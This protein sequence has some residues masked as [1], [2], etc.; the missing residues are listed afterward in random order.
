M[1][2]ITFAIPAQIGGGDRV[3][4]PL[5]AFGDKN[6]TLL[7]WKIAQLLN[8]T[9]GKNIL[10]SSYSDKVVAEAKSLGVV[11]EKRNRSYDEEKKYSH[12]EVVLEILQSVN[13][14]FVAWISPV[15]PFYDELNIQS[16]LEIFEKN[17][18]TNFCD[19]LI[20]VKKIN[21]YILDAELKPV[22]FELNGYIKTRKDTQPYYAY[23][24]AFAVAATRAAKKNGYYCGFKPIT[25]TLEGIEAI[26]INSDIE[27]ENAQK[28]VTA[29]RETTAR[30]GKYIFL[31]FD[32]VILDTATEA[33]AVAM[34][35]WNESLTIDKIN[36]NDDFA[37]RFKS[38]RHLVGPAWNYYYVLQA[39]VNDRDGYFLEILPKEISE[40]AKKFEIEY[41]ATRKILR[42]HMREGWLKLNKPYASTQ[43]FIDIIN[44]YENVGIITT[45]DEQT[46]RDL[47]ELNGVNRKL[48]IF[49]KAAYEKH[50]SKGRFIDQ[51]ARDKKIARMLFVDDSTEHLKSCQLIPHLQCLHARWG[52]VEARLKADNQY[53]VVAE[54]QKF[55]SS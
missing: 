55:I 6:H 35:V 49:D 33:Y 41:F 12:G 26:D 27:M 44:L 4:N 36:F 46:V 11:A 8:I 47:L 18:R 19:S 52:Y 32:G 31:D 3:R 9:D 54:I 2:N 17:Y 45:K 14:E 51:Y 42:T 23:V 22:N 29:Y 10:V 30:T 13:T 24:G 39:I 7:S 38:L 25:V 5:T 37:L 1:K 20:T 53:E 50:G 15:Y 48:N 21:E 28:T 34:L 40:E 43:K 16:A